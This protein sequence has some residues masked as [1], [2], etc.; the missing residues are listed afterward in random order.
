MN[1]TFNSISASMRFILGLSGLLMAG[2]MFGSYGYTSSVTKEMKEEQRVWRDEHNQA[3]NQQVQ[4]VS[5]QVHEIK[6]E[7]KDFRK[8][9]NRKLERL[10]EK[11]EKDYDKIGETLQKILEQKRM[12]P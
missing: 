3:V 8:E 5:Q 1:T 11:R 9:I 4:G 12:T 6:I 10:E 7:Q 2:V